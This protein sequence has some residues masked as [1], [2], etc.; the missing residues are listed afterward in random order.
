[1]NKLCDEIVI[2]VKPLENSIKVEEHTG[3][4]VSV[5]DI[6]LD[7]L[8]NCFQKGIRESKTVTSGFLPDNCLSVDISDNVK[9]VMMLFPA[10]YIDFTY[11]NTVYEHFPM[12][13]MVFGIVVNVNGITVNHRLTVIK[14]EKPNPRTPLYEYPFSN[15]YDDGKICI[16]AAN[17]LPVYKN[18]YA[19]SSLP[20][21]IMSLPNNDHNFKHTNN[22]LN[23]GYRDLLE[24]LK[25][26]EPSYYYAHIL[27]PRRRSRVAT[28][29][30]FI[31][32]KLKGDL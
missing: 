6:S 31:D 11:L 21:L 15:L 32:N 14:D 9:R 20:H 10:Q 17:S 29:Q 24:H 28:L 8:I 18:L 22:I 1:M 30:D 13:A 4:V 26:K 3:G 27:K 2:K 12:P 7:E 5:K 16:G 25:D 19:L 23:L